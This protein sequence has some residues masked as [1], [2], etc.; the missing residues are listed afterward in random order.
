MNDESN[1]LGYDLEEDQAVI[2][3]VARFEEEQVLFV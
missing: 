3:Y 1:Y 2:A